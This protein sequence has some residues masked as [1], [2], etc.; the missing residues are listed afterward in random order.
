LRLEENVS[1][2]YF[3]SQSS[4]LADSVSVKVKLVNPPSL[5]KPETAFHLPMLTKYDEMVYTPGTL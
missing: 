5:Y 1:F 4:H 3:H 2:K